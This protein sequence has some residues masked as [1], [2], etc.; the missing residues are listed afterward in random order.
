MENPKKKKETIIVSKESETIIK[1]S[2]KKNKKLLNE[3]S[4]Y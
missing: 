1:E 4:K 3:L 2:I